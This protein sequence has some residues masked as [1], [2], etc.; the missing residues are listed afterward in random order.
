MFACEMLTC[1]LQRRWY[2]RQSTVFTEKEKTESREQVAKIVKQ[3][4]DDMVTRWKEEMEVE[5]EERI[6]GC[7]N[8]SR[9]AKTTWIY[10]PSI[11][12][13]ETSVHSSSV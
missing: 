1:I 2:E 10:T 12:V 3:Y 5:E 4:S 7:R 8:G 11:L 9:P 6:L 13:L